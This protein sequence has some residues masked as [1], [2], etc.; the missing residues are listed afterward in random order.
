MIDY[1]T[2]E[3]YAVYSPYIKPSQQRNVGEMQSK[4][5]WT[6]EAL[7]QG[8]PGSKVVSEIE[9]INTNIVLVESLRF[10]M[11]PDNS[12]LEKLKAQVK[13]MYALLRIGDWKAI[14][15]MLH[16]AWSLIEPSGVL[17]HR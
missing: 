4:V 6:R 14:R 7:D 3:D 5:Y 8:F 9:D 16:E 1:P 11:R 12:A 10:F 13:R 2:F 17:I 15:G